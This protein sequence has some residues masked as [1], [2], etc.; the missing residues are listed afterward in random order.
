MWVRKKQSERTV[1]VGG[2]HRRRVVILTDVTVLSGPSP[3]TFADIST[4]QV[5]ARVSV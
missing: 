1:K 3:E 4:D 2:G 5:F